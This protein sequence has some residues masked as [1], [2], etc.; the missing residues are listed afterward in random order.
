MLI[1]VTDHAVDRYRQRIR[2]MLDPKQEVAR[3][4]GE[5]VQAG[6]ISDVP[7]E[8]VK[9][10]RGSTFVTDSDDRSLIYICRRSEHELLVVTL[11]EHDRGPASPRVPRRFT[12]R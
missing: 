2:G 3:R 10:R 6:R 4:V 5:A 1:A 12:D 11:W 9:A 7:P 8:G